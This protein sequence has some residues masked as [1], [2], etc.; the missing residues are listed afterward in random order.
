MLQFSIYSRSSAMFVSPRGIVASRYLPQPGCLDLH[1]DD[2]DF[3]RISLKVVNRM[4]PRTDKA[5]VPSNYVPEL[6]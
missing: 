4:W 2:A 5:H 6:R 3:R 1:P